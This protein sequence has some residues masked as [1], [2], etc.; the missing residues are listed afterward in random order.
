MTNEKKHVPDD[1][2]KIIEEA[3]QMAVAKTKEEMAAGRINYFRAME[4]MLSNYPKLRALMEDHEKYISVEIRGK[5]KSI[6]MNPVQQTKE[7]KTTEETLEDMRQDRMESY[8]KTRKYFNEIDYFVQ[9]FAGE[10]DFVAIRM[11]Y[12][13][14]DAEGN[15]RETGAEPY[16]WEDIAVE[17][18][19]DE[20]TLR[21]RRN[22]IIND[23]AMCMFGVDAAL[24]AGTFRKA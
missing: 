11:Y 12:F 5:S 17:L 6:V 2:R 8:K 23:M 1:M 14:E 22:K 4:L 3:V 9:V 13:G 7:H 18:K 15:R 24:S 21:R 20:K 16:T 19:K 10:K